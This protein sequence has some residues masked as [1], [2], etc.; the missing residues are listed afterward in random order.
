MRLVGRNLF[1]NCWACVCRWVFVAQTVKRGDNHHISKYLQLLATWKLIRSTTHQKKGMPSKKEL[2]AL[3][4]DKQL[5]IAAVEMWVFALKVI[6]TYTDQDDASNYL[7]WLNVSHSQIM[8][9][10]H[11]QTGQKG[12]FIIYFHYFIRWKAHHIT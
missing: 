11:V 1:K 10:E 6:S 9:G 4:K 2:K 7:S 12:D 8:V 3:A 5:D